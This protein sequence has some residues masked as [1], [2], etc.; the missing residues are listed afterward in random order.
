MKYAVG[1]LIPVMSDEDN[2][3][4]R[5]VIRCCPLEAWHRNGGCSDDQRRVLGALQADMLATMPPGRD[6]TLE[7]VDG[8]RRCTRAPQERCEEA[9]ARLDYA[10]A[11]LYGLGV[12]SRA[13]AWSLLQAVLVE[14]YGLRAAARIVRMRKGDESALLRACADAMLAQ[15]AYERERWRVTIWAMGA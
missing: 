9:R 7:P 8:G 2:C 11:C 3:R 12:R 4:H 6:E 14:G 13:R 5:R 1:S 10:Y 15:Q